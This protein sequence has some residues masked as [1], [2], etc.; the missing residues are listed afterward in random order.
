MSTKSQQS[1]PILAVGIL[2]AACSSAPLAVEGFTPE[3][4]AA[5][6]AQGESAILPAPLGEVSRQM[7][8]GAVIH[9]RSAPRVVV[10]AMPRMSS[11]LTE[12]R[13][14][15]ETARADFAFADAAQMFRTLRDDDATP[16]AMRAEF[17]AAVSES[18]EVDYRVR[19]IRRALDA[20]EFQR[21]ERWF[22][23]LANRHPDLPLARLLGM[24][25]PRA[26]GAASPT[27]GR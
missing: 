15:A 4:P 14:R 2:F 25:T 8:N 18:D 11:R 12:L 9:R 5:E 13:L 3:C 7:I 23:T 6:S 10:Q 20:A 22:R 24:S 16:V 19:E 1:L 27:T 26:F 21:A 17:H